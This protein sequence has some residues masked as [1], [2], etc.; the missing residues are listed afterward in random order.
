METL[1][2]TLNRP[3]AA[4]LMKSVAAKFPEVSALLDWDRNAS[5]NGRV[6]PASM[7]LTL[8]RIMAAQVIKPVATELPEIVWPSVVNANAEMWSVDPKEQ[9]T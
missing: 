9:T 6:G 2:E 1:N 5:T 3:M 7:D 8:D 4:Q